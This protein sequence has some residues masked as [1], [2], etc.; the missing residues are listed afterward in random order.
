MYCLSNFIRI[1]AAEMTKTL[2]IFNPEHDIALASNLA[3]FTAPHAGRRLRADLGWLP[4]IW[5]KE[6]DAVL[7]DNVDCLR[8][9][10]ARLRHRVGRGDVHFVDKASLS[11]LDIDTVEPWGWD[12][13][14]RAFL[15][16]QGV[17]VVPSEDTI[18]EIRRL[19][20]RQTAAGL[21]QVLREIDGTIG[22][23]HFVTSL[24]EVIALMAE[25]GQVVVKAPWSSSG[26]G[27][28]FLNA[29]A[30]ESQ[31]RWLQNIISVQGG[32][33]V[34]P[35]YKKV[36]DFGMEFVATADGIYYQ[37]LSLFH[38]KNGAY[39]GNILASEQTKRDLM[40]RYISVGLLDTVCNRITS[41]L[42]LG[43]YQ[44]P[45]GIDMMIVGGRLHPCVEI[46]L[47]RTMGHVALSMLPT[48][49][50]DIVKV[51]RIVYDGRSYKLKINN[52]ETNSYYTDGLCGAYG[53]R[54]GLQIRSVVAR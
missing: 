13:A 16:R 52:N 24:D 53:S 21:L 18:A 34:E 3:N 15:L 47:R 17:N 54:S 40:S 6:G 32:I 19:S 12:L 28:R 41:T 11:K 43:D 4:A 9:V 35:Y 44:G 51:M 5:A 1:F 10:W 7:V 29:M 36:K 20:H 50:E 14:L 26:R 39:T 31:R 30:D 37:G 33:M 25:F 46:N 48:G 49:T 45:F 42:D 2:H 8:K 38:T 22:E 27:V 23:A